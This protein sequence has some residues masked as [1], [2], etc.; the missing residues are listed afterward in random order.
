MIILKFILYIIL[1]FSF[2]AFG[3]EVVIDIEVKQANAKGV[4]E[5]AIKQLSYKL[6]NGILDPS[7]VEEKKQKINKIIA[8]KSNRYILYTKKGAFYQKK[9]SSSFVIPIT[10]GF[11]EENLQ[12]IL[13][14]EEILYSDSFHIRI[15]P[16]IFLEDRVGRENYGWWFNQSGK[17]V[18]QRS[19][20]SFYNQ[21][22]S[23]LMSYGFYL[24]NPEF[25]GFQNFIPKKLQARL[26]KKKLIFDLA[27]HLNTHLVLTGSV[28]IK[29]MDNESIF[30]VKADLIV[31]H[32]KSGR[33]LAEIERVETVSLSKS[34][35]DS[36]T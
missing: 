7:R 13:L 22:Q 26:P 31:Y 32:A 30:N 10:L 24:V 18:W 6:I 25:A 29:E 1:L 33:I 36:K 5:K 9:D 12:H 14:E 3:N 19:M 23:E 20:S 34:N 2:P 15:L 16:F 11:S 4:V 28:R 17:L 8:Q 27:K 35:S 21:L